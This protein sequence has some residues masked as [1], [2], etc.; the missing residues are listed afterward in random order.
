MTAREKS[1]AYYSRE[2]I[3]GIHDGCR[4]LCIAT[5]RKAQSLSR[6]NTTISFDQHLSSI[7][8]SDSRLRGFEVRLSASRKRNRASIIKTVIEYFQQQKATTSLCHLQRELNLAQAYSTLSWYSLMH[9]IMTGQCDMIKSDQHET[10]NETARPSS[11]QS[12][13][14]SACT[15]NLE[16]EAVD[17]SKKDES[18]SV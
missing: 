4:E 12:F 17:K 1:P 9:A 8:E 18:K 15:S 13:A 10:E 7:I 6:S 3:Q 2:E 5:I 16:V 11:I 14:S